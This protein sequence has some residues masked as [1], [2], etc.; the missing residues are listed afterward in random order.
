MTL[1][2]IPSLKMTKN[3]AKICISVDQKERIQYFLVRCVFAQIILVILK[4]SVQENK[5]AHGEIIY[6]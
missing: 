3:F 4:D 5:N 1:H 6:F 2:P